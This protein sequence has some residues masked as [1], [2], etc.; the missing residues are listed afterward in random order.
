MPHV[1]PYKEGTPGY[2]MEACY[3][4]CSTCK[5]SMDHRMVLQCCNSKRD[6]LEVCCIGTL[7]Q[8]ENPKRKLQAGSN[9]CVDPNEWCEYFEA[10]DMKNNPDMYSTGGTSTGSVGS[11][12]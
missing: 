7:A 12:T 8:G 2:A 11:A 5:Y 6:M 1:N 10:Q 9:Y 4:A 3:N